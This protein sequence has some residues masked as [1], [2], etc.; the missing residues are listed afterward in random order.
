VLNNVPDSNIPEATRQRILQA[1]RELDYIP[2][3]QALNLAKGK[4]MMIALIVRQTSEQMS[5]DAFIGEVIRGVTSAIEPQGYHLLVHTVEPGAPNRTTYGQLVRTRKADGLLITSPLVNDRE[6]Q[7]LHDEGTPI[8][9][10][11]SGDAP[12]IPSVD[13]DNVQGAYTAVKYLIDEGHRRIAHISNA[14]FSYTSSRDRLEGYRMALAEADIPYDD[15][16]VLE[17]DF[18]DTSGYAPMRHLLALHD[19]PTAIFVGS[20]VVALGAIE[21]LYER[22]LTIPDDISVIGFDDI[23]VAKHLRPPLTTIRLPAYEL[24]R[25]AGET[26][27]QI[28]RGE[29]LPML[30]VLLPTELIMRQSTAPLRGR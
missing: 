24:G 21:A 19:R 14:P 11:G 16:L 18:I 2:N 27:V 3:A 10:H 7:V 22:G 1:A 17:G 15:Q 9:L 8:V 25:R 29:T 12:D 28:I 4:T 6:V 13:V 20:D 26:M 23:W 30:R 5:G